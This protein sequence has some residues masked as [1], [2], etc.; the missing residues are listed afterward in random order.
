M[1]ADGRE[2]GAKVENVLVVPAPSRT[3]YD[4]EGKGFEAF[5]V[6]V[7]YPRSS[8]GYKYW[9]GHGKYPDWVRIRFEIYVDGRLEA[10]SGWMGPDDDLRALLVSGL[11]RAKELALVTRHLRIPPAACST[12]WWNGRFYPGQ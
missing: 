5:S 4:I 1:P 12:G 6:Q 10:H 11:A 2:R 7:D 9:A 3:I 8:K